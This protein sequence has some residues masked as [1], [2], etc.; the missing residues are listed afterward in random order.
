M[1]AAV[2]MRGILQDDYGVL[3]ASVTWLT[4]GVNKPGRRERLDLRTPPDYRIENIGDQSTL[5]GMLCAGEIDAIIS[6][7]IPES[8]VHGSG[9]TKRL[10]ADPRAEEITYFEKTRIFP[11]MHMLA[12]RR[13]RYE[14]DPTLATKLFD[15][16]QLAKQQS[17]NRLYDGDALYIMLPW[18]VNEIEATMA[19]M[20]V[21]FW[22]YGVEP[23]RHVLEAF[24]RHLENQGLIDGAL[25][26]E[27][28]FVPDVLTS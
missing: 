7:Q 26:L 20:G 2:W 4:G 14:K 16:F 5:D 12:V 8:F 28:L 9:G 22:P 23:N 25:S 27:E 10:F 11:I 13:E 18:L 24:V 21:D 3:P 19:T 15:A 17:L 6:P 1:T